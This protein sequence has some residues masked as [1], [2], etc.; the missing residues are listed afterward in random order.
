MGRLAGQTH[1]GGLEVDG[2]LR[3]EDEVE[4]AA[5][6]VVALELDFKRGRKVEGLGGG[7]EAGLDVVGLL[8]H[9]QGADLLELEAILVLDLLLVV[10]NQCFLLDV[11]VIEG[12]RRS[13]AVLVGSHVGVGCRDRIRVARGGRERMASRGWVDSR[14][15]QPQQKIWGFC[16]IA[17]KCK[18]PVDESGLADQFFDAN[19]GR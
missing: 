10:G 5:V 8:G 2:A 15:F 19:C 9:G 13:C 14:D 11:A 16:A 6:R 17:V 12:S 3:V 7:N 18:P 4:Q 1:G